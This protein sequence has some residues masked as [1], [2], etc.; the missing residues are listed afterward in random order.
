MRSGDAMDALFARI[1]T[2]ACSGVS[3]TARVQ[4]VE[5]VVER[6]ITVRK[7]Q[8]SVPQTISTACSGR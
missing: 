1:G 6:E 4:D 3:E 5:Y 2:V 8:S 7:V